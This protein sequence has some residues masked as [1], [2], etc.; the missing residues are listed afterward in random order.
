MKKDPLKTAQDLVDIINAHNLESH[1]N[2]LTRLRIQ[3]KPNHHVDFEK[4][5]KHPNVLGVV[6]PSPNE[7]QIVLGPGFVN[8]VTK[9]FSKILEKV[10]PNP[11]IDFISAADLGKKVKSNLRSKGNKIQ[12]FFTKFSKIFSP[13]II[14]FIG[15][16]ILAGIAGI[17]QASVGGTI[18]KDSPAI[19]RSWYTIL[20]VTLN[21]WKNAFIVIV[22]W[23]VASVYG[24]SGVL[25]AISAVIY[26]PIFSAEIAK[27]FIIY[28]DNTVNFLGW[29]ILNPS[30]NWLTVGLQPDF[31]KAG[32]LIFGAASGSILGAM[33]AATAALWLEKGI[34]KIIPHTL[35]M[36]VTPTVVL[37]VMLFINF[38][39]LL[40]ISGYLFFAVSFFFKHLH[41]NAFGAFFLA[42]IFL[43]TVSFGVHQGFIVIYAAL[44]RDTGVN[45]LFP[46][47]AMGGFAQ[48]GT[49]I[50]L[51]MRAQK[52][53]LLRQQIQGAIIPA[54]FGIGEPMIYGVTLPRIKPFITA[55]L[56]A[57]FGGFFIGAL[58]NWGGIT[59]GLNTEFGPSG[60]L[61]SIM[62]KTIDGKIVTAIILYLLAGL[63]SISMGLLITLFF[64][65]RIANAGIWKT[66]HMIK[67]INKMPLWQ[68]I[69]KWMLL[70][71][72]FVSV[73]G[74]IIYWTYYYYSL[75]KTRRE[76]WRL[77]KVE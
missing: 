58:M 60:I 7:L 51:W 72:L 41:A 24:G 18:D 27:I 35:D 61:A 42:M 50:A 65:S 70:G 48:I 17:L 37:F 9:E 23:R 69:W 67:N 6:N 26:A 56:G 34:R 52:N 75:P 20:N 43:S 76:E 21:V 25:G 5:K 22:G 73:I 32:K 74:F 40:P 10:N 44:I 36:V 29:H 4:I 38:F 64:Y 66:K 8:H 15:A 45:S 47:L 68:A 54:I 19:V 46:I 28:D 31:D 13:L 2:C 59:F 16:G 14:G 1:T 62:L 12:Q 33:L 57:G 39:V 49:G 77:I 11:Q 30:Y 53:S 3:L 63:I 55:S 71:L